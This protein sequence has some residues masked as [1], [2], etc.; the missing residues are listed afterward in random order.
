MRNDVITHGLIIDTPWIDYI[1]QGTKTWEM[2]TSHC[3]KR[4]KVALIKKG[5]KQVVAIA[6]VIASEGPLTLNQLRDTFEFH[7]VPEHIISQPDYK[8]H[9]AWKLDNVTPLDTPVYYVHK[10]GSVIWVELD[11][12]ARHQLNESY[13]L[14]VPPSLTGFEQMSDHTLR[15][16]DT[17]D[18]VKSLVP[19]ARDGTF[20]SPGFCSRNGIYTVGEKGDESKFR[21]F[22]EALDFLRKMPTARWRRPNENG[23]WGIVSAVEWVDLSSH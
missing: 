21:N 9:F 1:V 11:E 7:R 6:E 4:G 20:F 19:V 3:N 8:W 13:E 15:D 16:R 17:L 18:T 23:N 12:L 2:R 22:A 10:N 5:S 14:P